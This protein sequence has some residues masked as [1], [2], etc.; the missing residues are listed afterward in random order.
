M[1][2]AI[3]DAYQ[4]EVIGIGDEGSELL[5]KI[6][7]PT[8]NFHT[9]TRVIGPEKRV[10]LDIPEGF[11][12][13]VHSTTARHSKDR[14][15]TGASL[16]ARL[17]KQSWHIQAM[18]LAM[19]DIIDS[20]TGDTKMLREIAEGM[21]K[22]AEEFNLA[23]INGENAI[24]GDVIDREFNLSGTMISIAHPAIEVQGV[25]LSR[26]GI[27]DLEGS[28][29]AY[30]TPE[31]EIGE[32]FVVANSDGIGTK[33]RFYQRRN[34]WWPSINDFLAMILDDQAKVRGAK[35]KVASGV[36]ETNGISS[37]FMECQRYMKERCAEMGILGILQKALGNLNSYKP[38]T[39][40]YNIG[41]TAVG[42][43]SEKNLMNPLVPNP[44]DS[45]I[46]IRGNPNPRSNGITD[47]RAKMIKYLG[48]NW[49]ETELG[50]KFLEYLAEPSTVLYP[51]F[52]ELVKNNLATGVFHMSG[53]A[54]KGKFA[55]PLAKNKRFA[56]ISDLF[57][58]DWREI[59]LLGA[60]GTSAETAYGKYPM[61]NDGFITTDKQDEAEAIQVINNHG[62]QARV[63]GRVFDA[64]KEKLT[65]L[66]LQAYD[67]EVVYFPGK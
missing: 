1:A 38:D 25:K 46:A 55:R 5:A 20:R 39:P 52:R 67:G 44:R 27:F 16:V 65:G 26:E 54:Y 4:R 7:A 8:L 10:A 61:G 23:I 9:Y 45:V 63:V 31:K 40:A 37:Q 60:S 43:V 64:R 50:K 13:F 30:F 22:G 56:R 49:H 32:E 41:G 58:P 53:G 3:D 18:P 51:V 57:F 14:R 29:Y 21:V 42:V 2:K 34:L 33:T 48:D 35:V 6:C 59:T 24:L 12:V 11:K 28:T 62:L 17:W 47:K 66:E 19:T 15:K 36:I